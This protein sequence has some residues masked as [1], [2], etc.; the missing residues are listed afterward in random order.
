MRAFVRPATALALAFGLA[1]VSSAPA[2]A[3]DDE[4]R[5][6]LSE[7][8]K[9][10]IPSRP[11]PLTQKER[12]EVVFEGTFELLDPATRY[13]V[14]VDRLTLSGDRLEATATVKGPV[15]VV[16][17]LR[18]DGVVT[19]VKAFA[20]V[21]ATLTASAKVALDGLT[22]KITPQADRLDGKVK[23]N[24]VEP[25]LVEDAGGLV[26]EIVNDWVR[27]ERDGELPR[28]INQELRPLEINFLKALGLEDGRP[29]VLGPV[30]SSAENPELARAL[31][32]AVISWLSRF[33][34]SHP[35]TNHSESTHPIVIRSP[36]VRQKIPAVIVDIP[37]IPAVEQE[38][39]EVKV[40]GQVISPMRRVVI[41]PGR[42]ASREVLTPEREVVIPAKEVKVGEQTHESDGKTWVA[43]PGRLAVEVRGITYRDGGLSIDLRAEGPVKTSQRYNVRGLASAGLEAGGAVVLEAR[44]MLKWDNTAGR[45]VGVVTHLDG[46]VRDLKLGGMG[47]ILDAAR[48]AG[49]FLTGDEIDRTVQGAL[50]EWFARNRDSLRGELGRTLNEKLGNLSGR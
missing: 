38:I 47:P 45:P 17:K 40:F 32:A 5:K 37:A 41:T 28:R 21:D 11:I 9:S 22:L 8:L 2:L 19:Q 36:E 16:G 20:D 42:P 10:A 43:D 44:A 39:P 48:A 49:N 4:V 30:A 24:R 33:D 35:W 31:R 14:T 7:A 34:Q 1:A 25:E 13:A 29:P 18:L 6:V 50:N 3:G 23:V 12:G 46:S 27:D 15:S 26:S